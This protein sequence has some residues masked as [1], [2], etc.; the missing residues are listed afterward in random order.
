PKSAAAQAP[1]GAGSA[2]S[3]TPPAP[4]VAAVPS[5]PP[6]AKTGESTLPAAAGEQALAP[7]PAE[8]D[9]VRVPAQVARP[10]ASGGAPATRRF[11]NPM[12]EG[13]ALDYCR[14]LERDCGKPAADAFCQSQGFAASIDFTPQFHAPPTR[15]IASGQVCDKPIC[16]RMVAITCGAAGG[17]ASSPPPAQTASAGVP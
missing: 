13:M 17:G 8:A 16:A 10:P 3:P 1:A 6:P 7:P 2:A 5:E 11:D 14:L 15:V 12:V 9:F 4:S